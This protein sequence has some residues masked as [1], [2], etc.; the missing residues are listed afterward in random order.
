MARPLRSED[1]TGRWV[2]A[3]PIE[4][5]AAQDMLDKEHPDLT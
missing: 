2:C 3:L 1:Y 5:A 4:L